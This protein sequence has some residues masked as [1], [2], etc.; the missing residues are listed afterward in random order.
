MENCTPPTK[1][2]HVGFIYGKNTFTH[3]AVCLS[4]PL[5]EEAG[6]VPD[7]HPLQMRRHDEPTQKRCY[8]TLLQGTPESTAIRVK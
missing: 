7:D 4:I 1:F 3:S 2:Q 6:A 5:N 8:Y